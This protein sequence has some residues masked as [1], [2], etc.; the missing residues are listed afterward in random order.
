MNAVVSAAY[1]NIPLEWYLI[2]GH[3]PLSPQGLAMSTKN[4]AL[5]SLGNPLLDIQVRGGETL[6]KKYK[7]EPN[8]AIL[9]GEEHAPM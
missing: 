1:V 8:N 6:L 5:F 9:A 4:Y 3:G 7:L 2:R